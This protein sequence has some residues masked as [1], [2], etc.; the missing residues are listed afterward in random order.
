MFFLLV[1]EELTAMP[2]QDH[3]NN[4]LKTLFEQDPNG[5]A[6]LTG[7]DLT[8]QFANQAYRQIIPGS[9]QKIVGRQYSEVWPAADGSPAQAL[10]LQV[11][12]RKQPVQFEPVVCCLPNG[13]QRS[14]SLRVC[15]LDWDE[16][17]AVLMI[18]Q[19]SEINAPVQTRGALSEETRRLSQ[20][21]NTILMAM[22]DVVMIFNQQG[23]AI[24]ANP[25]ANEVFGIDPVGVDRL[26]FMRTL[27]ILQPD[28]H[29]LPLEQLPSERAQRGEV[30]TSQEVKLT[31]TLGRRRIFLV[32]ASP[33]LNE[34]EPAGVVTVWHDVSDRER[35]MEQLEIEQARLATIIENAPQ[36]ILVADEQGRLVQANPAAERMLERPLPYG[37]DYSQ[38]SSLHICHTDGEPYAP[39]MLPLVVSALDGLRQSNDEIMVV[40]PNGQRRNILSSTAPIVDRKGNLN[41]AVSILQDITLRKRSEDELRT[42]AGR[43]QLLASLSQAFAETGLNHGELLETIVREIG[44]ISGDMCIIQLVTDEGHW[45]RLAAFSHPNADLQRQVWPRMQRLRLPSDEGELG[46]VCSLGQVL[47]MA[48]ATPADM[49]R[50]F[51]AE[52]HPLLP[53]LEVQN[54]LFVPLRAHGHWIG[55]LGIMRARS[56]EHYNMEDQFFYQDLADRAALALEDARLYEQE[57]RRLRELSAL[58]VATNA[59]LSTIDLET[60]LLKILE[61]AQTAIPAAGQA[62]LYL[63]APGT[64]SLEVRAL[65]GFRDPRIQKISGQHIQGLAA[66]VVR[67]KRPILLNQIP[68]ES[69]STDEVHGRSPAS[70]S[71]IIA[72]LI[73]SNQ[74]LGALSL[75]SPQAN[76]FHESDL[77]L[78]DSF[79]VT[80]TTALHNATLYAEVQRLATT[81]TLTEQFNRR[82]FFELGEMEMHRFRRFRQP[83][84]AIMLDLDNFKEINDSF[85]HAAGDVVLFNVARRIRDSIRVVD[86]LGRYGGDEFAILLPDASIEDA[87]EIAERIRLAILAALIHPEQEV[88][89]IAISLGIAQATDQTDTLSGLLGRADAALYQAKQTGRNRVV[90]YHS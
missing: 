5:L 67:E 61:A 2:G 82:R 6:V 46:K 31:D 37:Q 90:E 29:P 79:A 38:L 69:Q 8:F 70:V 28:G 47:R 12:R 63:L 56:D 68:V 59:L 64:G 19:V 43:S 21:F 9:P 50:V 60:L 22:A 16:E 10:L 88:I 74:V 51:P 40:L 33:L 72:P 11:M 27:N 54:A 45:S 86:I 1:R 36:A 75:A 71:A 52:F 14:Y 25:A 57:A 89:S 42:Q 20:D 66:Q 24:H 18:M 3:A 84:S 77:R 85:G 44:G 32:S 7:P 23:Q 30:V 4:L 15:P 13:A 48:D 83:L 26:S 17:L 81:D 62:V 76:Q 87:R 35:L 55:C 41:G 73:I 80:A 39:R 49:E 58:H 65:S 53:L 34:S 78:L